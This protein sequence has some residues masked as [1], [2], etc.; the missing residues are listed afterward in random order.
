M[1]YNESATK[2]QQ[3]E[4]VDFELT[5]SLLLKFPLLLNTNEQLTVRTLYV[6]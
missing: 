6:H 3:I 5:V 2:P 4:H 1:L